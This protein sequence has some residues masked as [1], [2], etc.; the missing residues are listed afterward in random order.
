M[1]NE[2]ITGDAVSS[3]TN[4]TVSVSDVI[5]TGD[6]YPGHVSLESQI[7]SKT[8]WV[9]VG[10]VSG[11]RSVVTSDVNVAYRFRAHNVGGSVDVYLGP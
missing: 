7:P 2:T 10:T 4:P 3:S 6:V 5:V 8:D 9:V 1:I 11:A